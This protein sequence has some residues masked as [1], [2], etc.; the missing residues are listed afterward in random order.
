MIES[1]HWIHSARIRDAVES[2]VPTFFLQVDKFR[3][4]WMDVIENHNQCVGRRDFQHNRYLNAT[5]ISHGIVNP[6]LNYFN[7]V[8]EAARDIYNYSSV[9]CHSYTSFTIDADV[10]VYHKDSVDVFI[11]G[12][13]GLTEYK[14]ED[15]YYDIIPGNVL[16]IPK[17][18]MHG[19]T[20]RMPRSIVSIGLS[21]GDK[22]TQH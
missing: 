18:V 13:L 6:N 15:Q 11:I 22:T 4:T 14:V 19:A 20:P 3:T 16:Y 17:G 10:Y 7:A 2:R 1:N 21:N 5:I 12:V 9:S 8:G